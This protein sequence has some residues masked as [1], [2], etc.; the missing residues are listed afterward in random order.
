MTRVEQK[1]SLKDQY[2]TNNK[3]IE[4]CVNDIK[5]KIE[6]NN[7]WLL[8]CSCGNNYF[9]YLMNL[10]H[11]SIDIEP[12]NCYRNNKTID[13]I[14]ND[15]LT[16]DIN[17]PEK[18]FIMGFN[19]PFGLR[20]QMT[21][22]FLNKLYKYKPNYLAI[23]L[24]SSKNWNFKG[25]NKLIEKILPHNSFV[26]NNKPKNVPCT[27]FL[28][29]RNNDLIGEPTF[30][31]KNKHYKLETKECVV[32]RSKT[33]KPSEYS[34]AVRYVGAYAGYQYYIFFKGKVYYIDYKKNINILIDKPK[35]IIQDVFTLIHFS[36]KRELIDLYKIVEKIFMSSHKYLDKIAIRTN[37]NTNDVKRIIDIII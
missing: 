14:T 2:Y 4:Q 35:H 37:F 27:F 10:P 9:A 3:I 23:I 34:I 13:I 36:K 26:W 20:N 15:F 28:L 12:I 1:G 31:L 21:I 19:P 5:E 6:T 25:Y 17:L 30:L 16:T 22:K 18:E 24:L 11:I 33:D 8:D 32:K 29:E 7:L